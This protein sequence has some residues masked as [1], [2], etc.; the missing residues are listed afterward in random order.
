MNI[1]LERFDQLLS[2]GN[3]TAFDQSKLTTTN[4]YFCIKTS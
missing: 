1:T 4:K 3:K 2:E